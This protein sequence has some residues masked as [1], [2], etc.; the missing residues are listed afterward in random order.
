MTK[1]IGIKRIYII[2]ISIL[3]FFVAPVYMFA[4]KADRAEK[5]GKSIY[6][7]N[8]GLVDCTS[9]SVQYILWTEDSTEAVWLEQHLPA[10]LRWQKAVLKN[11]FN[12]NAF[13]YKAELVVDKDSEW[14]IARDIGDIQ[15]RIAGRDIRLFVEE[16]VESGLDLDAYID[17]SGITPMEWT[18]AG[19]INSVRGHHSSLPEMKHDNKSMNI[20]ILTRNGTDTNQPCTVLAVPVISG[21]I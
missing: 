1:N 3:L 2:V 9:A 16:R 20:Q 21:E 19:G 15:R 7:L 11:Y 17:S 18:A 8:S 4:D 5:D 6:L 10:N 14:R 12:Q 13:Q